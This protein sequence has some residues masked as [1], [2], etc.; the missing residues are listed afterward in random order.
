MLL[1][2]RLEAPRPRLLLPLQIRDHVPLRVRRL[3][4]VVPQSV[5]DPPFEVREIRS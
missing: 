3:A 5:H 4:V 2:S 1:E